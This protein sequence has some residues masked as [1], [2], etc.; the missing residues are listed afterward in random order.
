M[1]DYGDSA[2]KELDVLL[3]RADL[4]CN[5]L[6]EFN[7]LIRNS[8]VCMATAFM[9]AFSRYDEEKQCGDLLCG[10][11]S[12]FVQLP[13]TFD[14]L[15]NTVWLFPD[16]SLFWWSERYGAHTSTKWYERLDKLGGKWFKRKEKVKYHSL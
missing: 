5:E 13:H 16:G 1:E 14:D 11:L 12:L 15:G 8:W 2:L 4:G 10:G 9:G 3:K 6:G 7:L